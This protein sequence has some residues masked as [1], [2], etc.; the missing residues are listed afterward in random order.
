[1]ASEREIQSI[2][3]INV[4]VIV[5]LGHRTMSMEEVLAICPGAIIE[6]TKAYDESLELMVNN[7][8][9]GDGIAV[10]LGENFGIRLQSVGDPGERL[11][12]MSEKP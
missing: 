3:K 11:A 6:L 2:L 5:R 12:A 8:V 9:I 4:P 7:K 10:K 1:M